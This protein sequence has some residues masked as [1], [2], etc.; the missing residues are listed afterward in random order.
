MQ[1]DFRYQ[2]Y[3]IHL[4]RAW[5]GEATLWQVPFLDEVTFGLKLRAEQGTVGEAA[6]RWFQLDRMIAPR[7]EIF[8]DAWAVF[9][10]FGDLVEQLGRVPS[11][12]RRSI[13]P[14]AFCRLLE[15]CGFDDL[16]PLEPDRRRSG[17]STQTPSDE[18]PGR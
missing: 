7:L 11:G 6:V 3:F 9:S 17:R 4:T 15:G 1:G 13:G 10:T 8:D 14:V 2:R 12:S 16:T 5:Y 18:I